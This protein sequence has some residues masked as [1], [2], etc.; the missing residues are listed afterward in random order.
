MSVENS[1]ENLII[2]AS[3]EEAP[4]EKK[5]KTAPKKGYKVPQEIKR[6]IDEDIGNAQAWEDALKHTGETAKVCLLK[7][8]EVF[9]NETWL[10][11]QKDL[12]IEVILITEIADSE[13]RIT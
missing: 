1:H 4:A 3:G 8:L 7:T 9:R 11:R 6:L 2:S 12:N 5:A 13:I 10:T